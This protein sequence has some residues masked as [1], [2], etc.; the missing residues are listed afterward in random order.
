MK[1]ITIKNSEISE[2]LANSLFEKANAEGLWISGDGYRTGRQEE[3]RVGS[4]T[5]LKDVVCAEW[6]CDFDTEIGKVRITV[7]F[8]DEAMS[9]YDPET[10]GEDFGMLDW[11]NPTVIEARLVG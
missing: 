9:V 11:D 6:Y 4:Y 2:E 10:D 8:D 3:V 7:A 1:N 5:E